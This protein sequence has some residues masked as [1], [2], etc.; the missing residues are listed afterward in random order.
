MSGGITMNKLLIK[1][2]NKLFPNID[3][4]KG[5]LNFQDKISIVSYYFKDIN[6]DNPKIITMIES[7]GSEIKASIKY[8]EQMALLLNPDNKP[9]GSIR[10]T[11]YWISRGWSQEYANNKVSEIQ[12]INSP[13][14]N[15]YWEAKGL[16]K[17]E[18]IKKVSEFQSE[19]GKKFHR[20]LKLRGGT[21]S[22]WNINFW[23]NKGFTLCEAIELVKEK[24]RTNNRKSTLKYTKDE[25]KVFNPLNI[26]YWAKNYKDQN[27]VELFEEYLFQRYSNSIFRSKIADEFCNSL[28]LFFPESKLYFGSSEFGKYI[29]DVGYRKYDYIDLTN[30]ICVEF[31][32]NYWH[33]KD[34]ENDKTKKDFIESLGFRYFIVWESE[35]NKNKTDTITNLVKEI[36]NENC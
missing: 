26:E 14:S 18:A 6:Y 8:K 9:G 12:K 17:E 27:Y 29:P 20:R 13:R 28:S 33:T 16:S 7:L 22:C 36:K 30:M 19:S 34:N 1:N 5:Y 35:Y 24:Q 23:L 4:S 25:L 10:T 21:V 32:G 31:H 2:Y 3:L 15:L 11:K